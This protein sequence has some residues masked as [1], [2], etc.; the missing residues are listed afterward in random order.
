MCFKTNIILSKINLRKRAWVWAV[1]RSSG[2]PVYFAWCSQYFVNVA[3]CKRDSHKG[4]GAWEPSGGPQP[5]QLQS[6]PATPTR[7]VAP[8]LA[9]GPA[10]APYSCAIRG[11]LESTDINCSLF[12]D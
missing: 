4:T 11:Q 10:F 2:P 8:W 3:V 7:P 5:G 6:L 1:L 12:T 9:L